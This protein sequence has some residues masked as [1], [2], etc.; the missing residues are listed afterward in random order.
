LRIL[1]GDEQRGMTDRNFIAKP[2]VADT[3]TRLRALQARVAG[4]VLK[5]ARS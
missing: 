5:D 1:Q 2:M 3:I 4:I